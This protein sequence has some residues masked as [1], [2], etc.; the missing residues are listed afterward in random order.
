MP[1]AI[2]DQDGTLVDLFELHLKG[3][4]EVLRGRFG[5]EFGR[6]DLAKYYGKTGEEIMRSFLSKHGVSADPRPLAVRRRQW[7]VDNI[8]YCRVLPGVTNLLEGLREAG[9]PM[10][11]GTSNTSE[12]AGAIL[13]SCGLDGF[14]ACVSC[15]DDTLRGKPAPDVFLSAA[16]GLGVVPS[17]CVVVED[18]VFG[19]QAAKAAGMRSIAV[20]TGMHTRRELE[21]EGPDMLV[22][23]LSEVAAAT[24]VNLFK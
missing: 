9:V 20:S 5:L 23:S 1:A 14:F 4:Q 16:K 18:S 10:A 3:F 12:L 13:K 11:V 6:E 24:V 2:F 21:G 7:V 8:G 19:V 22:Y 17:E 15:R